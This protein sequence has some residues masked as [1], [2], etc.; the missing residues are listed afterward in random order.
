MKSSTAQDD[1]D[2]RDGNEKRNPARLKM[3]MIAVMV[4][5]NEIQHGSR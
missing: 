3:I 4:M 2:S 1:N 5:K